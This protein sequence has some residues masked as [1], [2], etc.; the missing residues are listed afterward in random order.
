MGLH[1]LEKE[2]TDD[3]LSRIDSI[4]ARTHNSRAEV[5]VETLKDHLP[6]EPATDR[7]AIERRRPS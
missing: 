1:K 6:A 4:S 2:L 7:K 3:L 5:V